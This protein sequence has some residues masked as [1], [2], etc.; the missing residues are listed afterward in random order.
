LLTF[1]AVAS[2]SSDSSA[3]NISP[4][5]CTRYQRPHLSLTSRPWVTPTSVSSA[6]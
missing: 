4:V 6:K 3:V 5:G 2:V 1:C